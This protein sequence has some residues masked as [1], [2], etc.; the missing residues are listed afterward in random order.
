MSKV[1]IVPIALF[2]LCVFAFFATSLATILEGHTFIP[3][4]SEGGTYAPQ[5]CVF[6]QILNVACV[7][8]GITLYTRFR[9]IKLLMCFHPD[10][11]KSTSRLNYYALWSGSISCTGLN[12]VANYQLQSLAS[13]HYIG[14]VVCFASGILYCWLESNISYNV[15]PHTGSIRMAHIR[16]TLA[17]ISS[18]FFF[19]T[20]VTSCT[21]VR[22]VLHESSE[23]GCEY[24]GVSVWSEWIVALV[25]CFYL[26]SFS[27]EF[28]HIEMEHPNI[29]VAGYE[30]RNGTHC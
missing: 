14:A 8:F 7:L 6:S 28:R 13:V 15:H 16:F 22:N 10:L 30:C 23:D 2:S 11:E 3:Y 17:A 9:Q 4:I 26:L 1:Y 24:L 5:S 18:Y 25:F 27:H 21:F 12:I 29:L 20:V 19:V